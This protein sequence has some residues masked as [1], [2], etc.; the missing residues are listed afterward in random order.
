MKTMID[1]DRCIDGRI[2]TAIV[3]DGLLISDDNFIRVLRYFS[4]FRPKM[5]V[6]T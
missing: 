2:L 1:I 6:R 3:I 4:E 5:F